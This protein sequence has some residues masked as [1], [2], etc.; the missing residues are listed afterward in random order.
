MSEWIFAERPGYLGKERDKVHAFWNKI[1]GRDCW[2]MAWQWGDS[3]VSKDMA[4]QIYEDA[5]YEFFRTQRDKLEWIIN[6]ASDVYDTAPSNVQAGLD[7]K[8]QETPNTHIHDVS[9]R[10]AIMRLGEKF[11]GNHLVHVRWKDS[12]GYLINPGV[13]PFHRPDLILN[14]ELK[15]YTGA[16]TWWF[17]DTIE[18]FYQKNKL[19]IIN[20]DA[21]PL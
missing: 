6:T 11:K 16:G 18:D 14:E 17:P 1:Y 9:I 20:N 13:V 3:V 7:Y 19:L 21:F 15:D 5:Y 4:I 12:E 2:K 8:V 10:R